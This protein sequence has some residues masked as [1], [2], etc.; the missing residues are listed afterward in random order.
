MKCLYQ[1]GVC[2][3]G[4]D[5]SSLIMNPLAGPNLHKPGYK[6]KNWNFIN[7]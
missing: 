5:L 7:Q 3:A 1:V 6:E 4:I 2:K